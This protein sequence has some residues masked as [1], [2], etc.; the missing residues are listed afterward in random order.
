MARNLE[1][2]REHDRFTQTLAYS[3]HGYLVSNSTNL[4]TVVSS[5]MGGLRGVD[6]S[7]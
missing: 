4:K 6:S 7:K 3:I 2:K 1:I 5:S